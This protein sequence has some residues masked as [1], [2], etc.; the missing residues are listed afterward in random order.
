MMKVLFISPLVNACSYY[1]CTLPARHLRKKGLAE[2]RV[3]S[4]IAKE[5]M[6]WADLVVV[7]RVVGDLM[8]HI[9][10]YCKLVGKKVVYELDDNIFMYPESPEYRKDKVQAET[11][12]AIKILR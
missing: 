12:S 3:V 6:D 7:Q 1:R 11:V 5:Y 4:S 9:I 8:Y 10:K 2:A